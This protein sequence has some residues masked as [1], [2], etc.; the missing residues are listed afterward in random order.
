MSEGTGGPLSDDDFGKWAIETYLP[1]LSEERSSSLVELHSATTWTLTL[2]SGAVLVVALQPGFPNT[3][4][5]IA[6]IAVFVVGV[7]FALRA[8][9][10]YINV[11][12]WAHIQRTILSLA[13]ASG[14]VSQARRAI[15]DYHIGW[16]SP[17][18][19]RDVLM[20][21]LFELG[22]GYILLATLGVLGYALSDAG[23][24]WPVFVMSGVSVIASGLEVTFF[25]RSNYM[26]GVPNETA[27]R[28]R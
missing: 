19:P 1:L 14:T 2:V 12:R 3:R 13:A 8:A 18:K 16:Q 17:L 5:V 6:L 23:G 21:C 4:S 20:K 22:Y 7:H 24:T 9:K 28:L 26:K 15:H 10:G 25:A 11:I 27:R